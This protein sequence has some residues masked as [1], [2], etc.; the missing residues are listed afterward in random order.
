MDANI[1]SIAA[2]IYS[3]YAEFVLFGASPRKIQGDMSDRQTLKDRRIGDPFQ[4]FGCGGV[5]HDHPRR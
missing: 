5:T 3:I 4:I 1:L 2:P